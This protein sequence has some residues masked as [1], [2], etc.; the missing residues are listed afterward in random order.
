M[1][2][3]IARCPLADQVNYDP[4]LLDQAQTCMAE[5]H[6]IPNFVTVDFYDRGDLF[7][8]VRALNG[9]G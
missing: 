4:F 7:A 1:T 6:H 3:P 8:A 9:L 2:D 5:R